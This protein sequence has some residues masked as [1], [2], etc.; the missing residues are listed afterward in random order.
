LRFPAFVWPFLPRRQA[1]A[2]REVIEKRFQPL[3]AMKGIRTG[4]EN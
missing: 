2:L 4:Q 3:I 1:G